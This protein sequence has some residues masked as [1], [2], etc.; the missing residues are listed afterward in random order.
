MV[1][2]AGLGFFFFSGALP[3][4]AARLAARGNLAGEGRSVCGCWSE[5]LLRIFSFSESAAA[6]LGG[7]GFFFLLSCFLWESGSRDLDLV[8]ALILSFEGN[9]MRI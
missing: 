5:W 2:S 3:F 9:S 1:G 4:V 7:L 6:F 8:S